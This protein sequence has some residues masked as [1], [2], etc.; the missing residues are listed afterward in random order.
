MSQQK[1]KYNEN[2]KCNI[3]LQ[4]LGEMDMVRNRFE[5][6]KKRGACREDFQNM[7]KIGLNFK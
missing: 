5:M 2:G 7:S 3:L 1:S 4:F 6:E